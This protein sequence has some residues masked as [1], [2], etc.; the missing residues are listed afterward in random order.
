MVFQV[1][2]IRFGALVFGPFEGSD[3]GFLFFFG[4]GGGGYSLIPASAM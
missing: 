1:I 3:A 2:P 4:W